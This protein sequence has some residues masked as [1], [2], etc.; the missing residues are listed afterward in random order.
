MPGSI[1]N[2]SSAATVAASAFDMAI[3]APKALLDLVDINFLNGCM[4]QQTHGP[5]ASVTSRIKFSEPFGSTTTHE[6]VRQGKEFDEGYQSRHGSA[7]KGNSVPL[8]GRVLSL[9]DF[10]DTDAVSLLSLVR[11]YLL[12]RQII[13]SAFLAGNTTNETLGPHCMEYFMPEFRA[14]VAS[15]QN[16]VV[17]GEGFG[18][19]SSR[20]VAVNALLGAGVQCV[21]AKS[22]SFIYARNQPNLGLLG[23]VLTDTQFYELAVDGAEIAVDLS[24]RHILCGGK[25]FPFQLS[26]VEESLI[27][28]GGLTEA[29]KKFGKDVFN[30]LC[31]PRRIGGPATVTDIEAI[32]V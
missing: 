13:P 26:E 8:R 27:E 6:P 7:N 11:V 19:G 24:E 5:P 4:G 28:A 3:T 30:V 31:T 9:G 16:V 18:C 10:I 17:A 21:V 20:D 14:Q 29:F 23:I 32:K 2:L 25:T 22:F 12:T 15:G 1:A